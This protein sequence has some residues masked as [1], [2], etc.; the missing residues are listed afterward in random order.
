MYNV[1]I[2]LFGVLMFLG[3]L[4]MVA[5]KKSISDQPA[6]VSE[7]VSGTKWQLA[8]LY[9]TDSPYIQR[10]NFT[11]QYYS[12]CELTDIY[13][14]KKDNTLSRKRTDTITTCM[15]ASL[16][17]PDDGAGWQLDSANSRLIITKQRSFNPYRYDCKILKLDKVSMELQSNFRNYF[18]EPSAWIFSFKAMP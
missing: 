13:E 3:T 16:L 8:A 10:T 1:R 6:S 7:L 14:F 9:L 17:M 2:K 11:T 4:H 12:P 15:P 5:C 18:N